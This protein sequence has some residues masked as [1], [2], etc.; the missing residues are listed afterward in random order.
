MKRFTGLTAAAALLL[1]PA[2]ARAQ[3]TLCAPAADHVCVTGLFSLTGTNVLNVTLFN[4]SDGEG[5]SWQSVLTQLGIGGLPTAGTWT[6]TAAYF[7][8]W[9]GTS[10]VSNGN[11]ALALNGGWGPPTPAFNDLGFTI[12]TGAAGPGGNGGISTCDGP[13]GGSG[14]KYRTCEGGGTGFGGTDDWFKFSFTYSAGG[15][16]QATL[17]ALS[18]GFKVQAAEGVLDDNGHPGGSFECNTTVTDPTA[19]KYCTSSG[20]I[21]FPKDVVP[22]PASMTLL[23]FGLVG[24]AAA[25]RRRRQS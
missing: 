6:L 8:D 7:N 23:A 24:M 18:W 16:S 2:A 1:A 5:V 14:T 3:Q 12:E 17:D 19:D 20:G 22:E 10:L 21:S 25:A 15:L 11:T 4:G 9:N 13:T